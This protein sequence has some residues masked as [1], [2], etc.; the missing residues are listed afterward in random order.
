MAKKGPQVPLHCQWKPGQSGNPAGRKKLPPEIREARKLCQE[1]MLLAFNRL[2][3]CNKETLQSIIRDPNTTSLDL[4]MATVIAK[5]I[6]NGDHMRLNFI[7]DRII[8][9]VPDSVKVS[10]DEAGFK[11]AIRNYTGKSDE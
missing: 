3:F 11:I 5:G 1:S 7:F 8:G 9:K 10:A 6:S 2:I 4:L